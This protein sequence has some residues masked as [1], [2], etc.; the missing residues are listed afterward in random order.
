VSTL[1][2]LEEAVRKYKAIAKHV[3]PHTD[4]AKDIIRRLVQLR[5]KL[6]EAKVRMCSGSCCSCSSSCSSIFFAYSFSFSLFLS[7]VSFLSL[8]F[9]SVPDM[10]FFICFAFAFLLFQFLF[11]TFLVSI[12]YVLD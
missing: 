11:K 4:Q 12:V 9:F 2:A 1:E 7:S 3:E 8:G 10:S 6:F 5:L